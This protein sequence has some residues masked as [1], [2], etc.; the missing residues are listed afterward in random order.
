M[1]ALTMASRTGLPKTEICRSWHQEWNMSHGRHVGDLWGRTKF[2]K[3]GVV[4][5]LVRRSQDRGA[6]R[7]STRL[8]LLS[9]LAPVRG[10]FLCTI[11]SHTFKENVPESCPM[12][13]PIIGYLGI[14]LQA[15]PF[16][17]TRPLMCKTRVRH[18]C[19]GRS[20]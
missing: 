16:P 11:T 2:E 14:R 10:R 20:R 4:V 5:K 12:Q 19:C 17:S 1:T 6:S 13:L 3:A 18:I 15:H 8:T 7:S 9:D